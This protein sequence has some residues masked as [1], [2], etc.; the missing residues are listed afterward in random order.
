VNLLNFVRQ[1]SAANPA[2]PEAVKEKLAKLDGQGTGIEFQVRADKQM[3]SSGR[4]P[5]KLFRELG[6]LKED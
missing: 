5:L 4:V 1:M 6:R 2:I 3:Y